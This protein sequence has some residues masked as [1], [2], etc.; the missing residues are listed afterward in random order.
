VPFIVR[1]PG[2]V[3]A[4]ARCDRLV[5]QADLMATFAEVLGAKLPAG[6]GEDSVS[7]LPLLRGGDAPVREYAISHASSG[8]PALRK[9]G[10]KIIFGQGGGGYAKGNATNAPPGQLYDLASDLV[11][12]KNLWA[13][14]PELVAELTAT[15][16]RLVAA[17]PNDVP[18][19]WR[20]FLEP[21]SK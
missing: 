9:G 14:K 8:L 10:W 15:M 5:H 19:N 12:T 21:K 17:H 7:L 20:R 18:V 1:W 2:K 4:G 13:E 6:A 16:E 3:Q 11:E